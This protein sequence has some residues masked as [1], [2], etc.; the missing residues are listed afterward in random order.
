MKKSYIGEV[1][2]QL[3][4]KIFTKRIVRN[5]KQ[6]HYCSNECRRSDKSSFVSDWTEERRRAYSI[7]NSGENNPNFGNRWSEEQKISA[8]IA[9]KKLYEENPEYRYKVGASNRGV[10]FSEDRIKRMHENRTSESYRH[11]PSAEVR[12]VISQKSKEK[13]TDDYREKHRKTMEDLGYWTPKSQINPYRLYYKESNWVE[14]MIDYFDSQSLENLKLYGIFSKTNS[15]G[16]V[17]DHI[18]PR[19]IGYEYNIPPCIMRHPANLQFISHAENVAK[20]FLDRRL[21]AEE[22][23]CIINSLLERILT[24]EKSWKEQDICINFIKERRLF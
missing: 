23:E 15:K 10:K 21:T 24:F 22:K 12:K 13:W 9:K 14:R 5:R 2:C 7:M 3:C 6:R 4:K 20:G 18:V 8:S 11:Y 16:F 17:R 19:K 1:E